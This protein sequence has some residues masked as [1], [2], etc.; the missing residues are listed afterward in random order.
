M[1]EDNSLPS[2]VAPPSPNAPNI[3]LPGSPERRAPRRGGRTVRR[4]EEDMPGPSYIEDMIKLG[5]RPGESRLVFVGRIAY[6]KEVRKELLSSAERNFGQLSDIC[7]E[8]GIS[9]HNLPNYLR[10]AGLSMMDLRAF[11][12]DAKYR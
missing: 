8:Q 4:P 10:N 5:P 6:I 1:S 2:N 9:R 3:P 12:P 7:R 11:N